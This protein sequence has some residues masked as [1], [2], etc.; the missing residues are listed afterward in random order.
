LFSPDKHL[1]IFVQISHLCY[2]IK[3]LTHRVEAKMARNKLDGN[4]R[5]SLRLTMTL[6]ALALSFSILACSTNLPG[7]TAPNNPTDVARNVE[8]T[9]NA[10][11]VATLQAQETQVASG[12]KTTQTEDPAVNTTIQAQQVTLDAQA[13]GMLPQVTQ[14]PATEVPLA[15]VAPTSATSPASLSI[16]DWKMYFWVPLTS[17]CK[18]LNIPCWKLADDWKTAQT[19]SGDGVLTSKVSVLIDPAWERPYLVFWDKRQ[20]RRTGAVEIQVDGEWIGVMNV[21]QTR[22]EWTQQTIDL[23]PY[24]G[25]QLTVR[26]MAEIGYYQQSTWFIQDVKIVPNFKP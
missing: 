14:P 5:L 9:I 23:Q 10:E 21:N 4:K 19:S 2:Q 22:A 24:K 7:I 1:T 20:L 11:T 12:I 6:V 26:F 25:K 17:G 8:A 16:T 13:T 3:I 18:V 15:T